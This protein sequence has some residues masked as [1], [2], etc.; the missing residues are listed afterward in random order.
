LYLCLFRKELLSPAAL[1]NQFLLELVTLLPKLP[2]DFTAEAV[3][4]CA[5]VIRNRGA[6]RDEIDEEI[7]SMLGGVLREFGEVAEMAPLVA[8]VEKIPIRQVRLEIYR[9][10]GSIGEALD[11]LWRS[12][13]DIPVCSA[14]CRE[15][16][17]PTAAFEV[18][19]RHLGAKVSEA[20][21]IDLLFQLISENLDF[22]DIAQA[23]E[24]IGAD[25]D[26]EAIAPLIDQAYRQLVA[27][28]KDTDLSAALAESDLFESEFEKRKAQAVRVRIKEGTV[29]AKCEKD[30]G[31]KFVVR[32]V[33]GLLY[34]K[35]CA[36]GDE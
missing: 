18:L 30:L 23:L 27:V 14:F 22:I 26:I 2:A 11:L 3:P 15:C 34:H 9:A 8:C 6:S 21:R 24:I 33:D 4:F 29:C 12:E 20:K 31:L 28:R 16:R 25:E 36:G 32:G 5:C 19:V 35:H 13:E 10:K 7:G 1:V 17:D